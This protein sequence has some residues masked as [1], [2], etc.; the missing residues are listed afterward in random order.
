M[1]KMTPIG[2]RLNLKNFILIS[3]GVTELLRKASPGE[4]IPPSPLPGEIG[5]IKLSDV[6]PSVTFL[7]FLLC[8]VIR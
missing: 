1:C 2:V 6:L 3:C 8:N 4:R 5:L 7:Y